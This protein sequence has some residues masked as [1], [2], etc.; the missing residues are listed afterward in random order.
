MI[1]SGKKLVDAVNNGLVEGLI[2]EETQIQSNGVDLTVGKV[3][4]FRS[5]AVLGFDNTT[6]QLPSCTTLNSS[7]YGH[8]FLLE[9][10]Y[11]I[12]FNE[13][14]NIPKDMCAMGHPRSSLLRSG[15]G[16]ESALWDSG[17]KGKG[18]CL[19][20]VG[21]E[22][23]IRLEQ[24]ARIYQLSFYKTNVVEDGYSGIYQY[25]NIEKKE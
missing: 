24:D 9:G 17:Y 7:I 20:V 5:G 3:E 14:V 25:E 21:N 13:T 19:L 12:T 22:H 6:R 4:A 15:C 10:F 23:G 16:I 18:S 2:D 1:L 11:K 8:F